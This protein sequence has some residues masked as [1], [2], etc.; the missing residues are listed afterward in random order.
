MTIRQQQNDTRALAPRTSIQAADASGIRKPATMKHCFGLWLRWYGVLFI[1]LTT[2]PLIATLADAEQPQF[3]F[4]LVSDVQYADKDNAIGRAYRASAAK[5][6]EC[7]NWWNRMP[8]VFVMQLGDFVDS[9]PMSNLETISSVMGRVHVPVRS[10]L[11]N[12]EFFTDRNVVMNRLKMPAAY[13]TF[14]QNNWQFVVLDGMNVSAAGGWPESDPH[15]IL[16][17][18]ILER[19]TSSHAINAKRWN[20]AI[21]AEQ[22]NWLSHV[23]TKANNH[24]QRSL[25]FC[26]MPTLAASCRP[27][28]LLWD[29]DKVLQILQS[30]PSVAAYL[31]GHDHKG[32]YAESNHIH[33]VTFPALV[34][35]ESGEACKVVNVYPNRL[36][37]QSLSG[38]RQTLE[39]QR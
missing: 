37:I 17:R 13:Y 25:V 24:H 2:L 29:H 12:H 34:E 5:L 30:S 38:S 14:S 36:V 16:G 7:V 26:H 8:V 6:G 23:L 35:H 27:V 22:R 10:V 1:A 18:E 21:G 4:G 3:S 39:L 32:G 9:G 28:H 11:G 20:G 31:N 15:A 19:L 33:Y